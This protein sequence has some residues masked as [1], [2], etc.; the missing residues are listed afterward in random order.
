VSIYSKKYV[1]ISDRSFSIPPVEFKEFDY[2]TKQKRIIKGRG[3]DIKITGGSVAPAQISR[4]GGTRAF[5]RVEDNGSILEDSVYYAKKEYEEKEAMLPFYT[6][7]SF[8][9]GMMAMFALM[10]LFKKNKRLQNFIKKEKR[11]LRDYTAK[12]ALKIL[13]PYTS[14][15]PEV[16]D[17]VKKLYL[18]QKGKRAMHIID[19][20][21][22]QEIIQEYDRD[23]K[24]PLNR[25]LE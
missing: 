9:A 8:L 15:S 2:T 11:V 16:E 3:F 4:A 19:K 25:D 21:R 10:K 1:F 6:L 23:D 24:P 22:L 14:D 20:K 12:E 18:I 7:A 17:L 5:R 13:Y